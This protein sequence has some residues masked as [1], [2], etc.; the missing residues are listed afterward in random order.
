MQA[1]ADYFEI[2]Q[3]FPP[4]VNPILVADCLLKFF[5]DTKEPLLSLDYYEPFM[6]CAKIKEVD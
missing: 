6:G 4:D 3:E 5:K 2:H 1:V